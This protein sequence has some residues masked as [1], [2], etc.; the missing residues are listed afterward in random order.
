MLRY[1]RLRVRDP[2]K[3]GTFVPFPHWLRENRIT[4]KRE[5]AP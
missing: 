1:R 3:W 2:R 5:G 4:V